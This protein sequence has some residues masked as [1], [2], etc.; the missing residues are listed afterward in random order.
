MKRC[1]IVIFLFY[2]LNISPVFPQTFLRIAT[3]FIG[4]T[5]IYDLHI[6][7]Q[8]LYK[9]KG[10]HTFTKDRIISM[11]DSTL[12]FN[13]GEIN[14]SDIKAVRLTTNNHLIAPFKFVFFAAGIGFLPL[15]TLN[16]LITET[17]PVYNEKAAYISAALFTTGL[18]IRELGFKRI[19][20]TKNTELKVLSLNFQNLNS[21]DTLR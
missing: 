16:N 5:K 8:F 4:S 12:V 9:L 3:N 7:E 15:N 10:E 18:I 1:K 2:L 6:N 21:K 14:L 20:I 11:S 17:S 19:K 13:T